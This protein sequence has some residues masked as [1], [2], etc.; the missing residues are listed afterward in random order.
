MKAVAYIEMFWVVA[1]PIY[2]VVRSLQ[3]GNSTGVIVG[4]II[5][6]SA[7][8]IIAWLWGVSTRHKPL[9]GETAEVVEVLPGVFFS[10][11]RAVLRAEDSLGYAKREFSVVLKN[12]PH[13]IKT[14]K[15]EK[16]VWAGHRWVLP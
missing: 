5:T 10:V 7:V 14:L 13:G 2:L 11:N 15:G 12:L 6:I 4:S 8:C 1:I 16:L 9:E 3:T